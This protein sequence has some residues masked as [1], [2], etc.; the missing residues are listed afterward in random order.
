[1][2]KK[3]SKKHPKK[4]RLSPAPHERGDDGSTGTPVPP[5]YQYAMKEYALTG[6]SMETRR[7]TTLANIDDEGQIRPSFSMLGVDEEEEFL[8]DLES[9]LSPMDDE[10]MPDEPMTTS[11]V[12]MH[13]Q[14]EQRKAQMQSPK[15]NTEQQLEGILR[16]SSYVSL[17]DSYSAYARRRYLS[18]RADYFSFDENDTVSSFGGNNDD[19]HSAKGA[20][21]FRK[22]AGSP[23]LVRHRGNGEQMMPDATYEE[24]YGDAYIGGPIR[25]VYP[26]GY[27][28]MRPRGGPWRLSIIVCMLFTWLSIFVIGHCSDVYNQEGNNQYLD[29]A[30]VYDD[31]NPDNMVIDEKWCGSRLLYW[32]WV[33]SMLITGL[34][35]AYCGVI[36][37]IKVRDFAVANARSQPPGIMMVG[38]HSM[39]D[40]PDGRNK[41]NSDFYVP[42]GD[43]SQPKPQS[44]STT[45]NF[46]LQPTHPANYTKTIYQA[47]GTPQFWGNQIYRPNQAAVHTVSR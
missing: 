10:D 8:A 6:P 36:G 18:P 44:G 22:S 41:G 25:Y 43:N 39:S 38:D 7:P 9:P 5:S 1:M 24:W 45:T 30:Y 17:S 19:D 26:S 35:S 27:Q 2:F 42:I 12:Q 21:K 14:Q 32:M 11:N 13:E 29:D 40:Y 23:G 16:A 33:I 3:L 15:S 34:A 20:P 31:D 47:D 46:K 4:K 28:S 37:Y